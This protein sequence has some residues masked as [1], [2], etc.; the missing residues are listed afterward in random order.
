[1]EIEPGNEEHNTTEYVMVVNEN[2][3]DLEPAEEVAEP[4]QQ[5]NEQQELFY[6]ASWAG[7]SHGLPT[8]LHFDDGKTFRA[9]WIDNN[10]KK[11][12]CHLWFEKNYIAPQCQWKFLQLEQ[13][14]RIFEVL[15][16]DGRA[17]VPDI[18]YKNAEEYL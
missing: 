7:P 1:M 17:T 6:S 11:I 13:V 3:F 15:T 10:N 8:R 18:S 9:K 12:I 5:V 2:I 14:V 16:S 4:T